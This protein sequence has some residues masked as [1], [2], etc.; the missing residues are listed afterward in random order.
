MNVKMNYY[1]LLVF[2]LTF[3]KIIRGPILVI[4]SFLDRNCELALFYWFVFKLLLKLCKTNIS[5]ID[6]F[7]F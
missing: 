7:F 5:L 1:F 4:S 6:L 3:I 2:F